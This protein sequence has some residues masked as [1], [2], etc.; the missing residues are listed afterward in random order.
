M[1]MQ[2][3]RSTLIQS[4]GYDHLTEQLS[5]VLNGQ[6]N[7]TWNYS[8]VTR[9]TANQ[10]ADAPSKGQFFNKNIRGRFPTTKIAS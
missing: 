1:T 7:T 3:V 6:Q 8:G 9:S 5:V 4:I 10:F 2:N